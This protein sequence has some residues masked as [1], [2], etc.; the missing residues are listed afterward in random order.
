MKEGVVDLGR[1]EVVGVA[2]R[3]VERDENGRGFGI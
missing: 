3:R 2:G 1:G